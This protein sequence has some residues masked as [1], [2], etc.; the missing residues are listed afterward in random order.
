MVSVSTGTVV[1]TDSTGDGEDGVTDGEGVEDCATT[2]EVVPDWIGDSDDGVTEG[3][4]DCE[5]TG[6][7]VP[8]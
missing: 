5:T 8:D 4:E 6:V 7:V 3:V 1:V 2:G